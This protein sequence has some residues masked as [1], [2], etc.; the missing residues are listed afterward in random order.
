VY[1]KGTGSLTDGAPAAA[2]RNER[3]RRAIELAQARP[4]LEVK[5]LRK[6]YGG[7]TAVDGV[8]FELREGEALG[9]IGPNGSGKT[10]TFDLISG[11]QLPTSGT[12]VFDGVDITNLGP[13]QRAQRKL[14][15]RFQDARL[16]PS[17]TVFETILVALEQRLEVRSTFLHAAGL[18]GARKSERRARVRAERLI[19]LLDLGTYR[20]KF[21]KE[22]STGLRRIV[23]L[24]CVL[25]SE[26]KLLLLDEPSSG[27]AQ[28]EAEGLGPLLRRIRFETGCS[29]LIIEHDMPLISAVADELLA[30]ER[31]AVVLRGAPNVVLNDERVIESYLGGSEAAI[32]RSGATPS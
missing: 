25:A 23:D 19:E 24:A 5:D 2:R 29:L 18:P 12:V 20:D 16:F 13:E 31:G 10:T 30:L 22:L 26:P 9:L 4:I 27:I 21:V 11:Y 1:V 8:S 14:V 15:R 3:E 17:L 7:V 28:A 6:I 32:R